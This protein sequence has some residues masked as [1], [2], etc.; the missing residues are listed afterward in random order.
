HQARAVCRRAER[1]LVA[2]TSIEGEVVGDAALA[3]VNRLSD[4]LFVAARAAND[5]GRA[6]VLW[7]P[8]ANRS[9]SR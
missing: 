8:G 3:Y 2:L 6:D 5:D 7:V 1:A 4:Y 9:E